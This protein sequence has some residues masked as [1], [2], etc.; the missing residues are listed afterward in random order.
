[1]AVRPRPRLIL[2]CGLPGSGKTTLAKRLA[3]EVPA[4]RLCPDEWLA[5]L[6]MDL[7]DEE[8]RDRLERQFW[9][10]A[11]NLLRL[12]Q[13]VVLEFGFWSRSERNDKRL[14]ARAL[15]AVV[16]LRYLTA[17]FEELWRRVEAR[18]A[19][20]AWGTVPLSRETLEAYARLFEAPDRAELALFDRPPAG[21][22]C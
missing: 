17:P 14:A 6:G 16:E 22:G 18:S 21:H 2:L 12:G 13:N 20:A 4:V 10:H 15:G 9:E 8:V 19:E 5:G 7:Y 1:M 11:G 3:Q